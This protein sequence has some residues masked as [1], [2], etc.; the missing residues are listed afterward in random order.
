MSNLSLYNITNSI[1]AIMECEE[2]TEEQRQELIEEITL[3]LQRKSRQHHWI[4]KEH[5]IDY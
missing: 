2:I 3:E 5:R 4:Y 1:P